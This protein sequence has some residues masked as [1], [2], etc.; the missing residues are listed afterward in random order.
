MDGTVKEFGADGQW[1]ATRDRHGNATLGTY[2]NGVLEGVAMPDGRSL[3][4][5]YHPDGLVASITEVGVDGVTSRTWSYTWEGP[6]LARID[7]PD[8]TAWRFRYDDPAHPGYITRRILRGT[9]GGER[10]EDAREY[11]AYGN[12]V[13]QWKGDDSPTGPNA[14]EVTSYSYPDPW[15]PTEKVVTDP[16]G[17]MTT[18]AWRRDPDSNIPLVTSS[19][20]ECSTC[21][22][23]PNTQQLYDDSGNPMKVTRSIDARGTVTLFEYDGHGQMTSRTEAMGTDLERT[24]TWEYH[25]GYSSLVTAVE[26]SSTSG[27]GVRRTAWVYDGAGN[28]ISQTEEGVE[29]GEAFSYETVTAY[30]SAGQPVSIDPPGYGTEDQTLFAYDPARG[31]LI[32][33]S[34]TDPIIGATTFGYDAFNRRTRVTDVNGVVTETTYDALNRVISVVQKGE[35]T[36]EDLVTAQIY[37]ASGDL[38]RTI[39]PEGNVIEYGYDTSGRLVSI[40]RKP[41]AVT[42]GERTFYTLDTVGHRVREDLQRWDGAGWVTESFTG[43]EYSTRCHLDKI[44][45]ADGTVTEYAYDC[46]GNRERVWDANHPSADQTR[47]PT[48]LYAYDELDRLLTV[49]QP[50]TG[51]GGGY[52]VTAYGYDVQDHLVRVTD[53]NGTVTSFVYSDRDLLTEELSEVSGRTTFRYNDHGELI[54]ETDARGVTVL[55]QVDALDRVRLVDYPEVDHDTTYRYDE[56]A[57]PF[58]KGRLTGIDRAG[59]PVDY[60]YDRFGRLTQDGTLTFGYDRNGNRLTVGYP[61][62]AMARYSYDFADRQATLALE[63]AG[64]ASGPLV[65]A[66]SY[67][68]SGPLSHLELGNGLAEIREFDA[69]YFPV[70]I[71]VGEIFDWGAIRRTQWATSCPSL[72]GWTRRGHAATA[73][74]MCTTS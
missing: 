14:T 35:T 8:G 21:G 56:A 74:R 20:G 7:R 64:I 62:G 57:V 58:S 37:D 23:G 13:R 70:R 15:N 40:E 51:E 28:A 52:A 9:D 60:R 27:S 67:L 46:E 25:E 38:F 1:T 69:R 18:T 48:Q 65:T 34:R 54:E 73:T 42:P 66:A 61:G 63:G 71:T 50:W 44:L 47:P 22:P 33:S 59:A 39:L 24:T 30:N 2:S 26:L 45:H 72:T 43:F 16:L 5:S 32:V 17:N 55:R 36:A 19:S 11:D 49:T 41:D 29:N 31:D 53:A 4:F 68:P 6:D 12:L 10:V 3:T